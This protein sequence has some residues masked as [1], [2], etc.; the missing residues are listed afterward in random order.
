MNLETYNIRSQIGMNGGVGV[1]EE[2]KQDCRESI[3]MEEYLHRRRKIK[4]MSGIK[5]RFVKASG[6]Y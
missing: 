1:K 3:S 6:N 4:E 2:E 5:D